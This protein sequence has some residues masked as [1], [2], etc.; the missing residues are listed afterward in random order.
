MLAATARLLRAGTF[1]MRIGDI[2]ALALAAGLLAGCNNPAAGPLPADA[3]ARLI[4]CS[5]AAALTSGRTGDAAVDADPYRTGRPYHLF[6]MAS[7]TDSG[8]PEAP[9]PAIA[10]ARRDQ[11]LPLLKAGTAQAVM[12]QCHAAYPQMDAKPGLTLPESRLE[13]LLLCG[14]VSAQTDPTVLKLAGINAADQNSLFQHIEPEA[15]RLMAERRMNGAGMTTMMRARFA[16]ALDLGPP[17]QL[18]KLCHQA[19]P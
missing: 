14:A 9:D 8:V 13:A 17:A 18:L 7:M 16:S 11:V 12:K 2:A 5:A 15:E 1:G 3:K 19:Y 10:K 4:E 6:L